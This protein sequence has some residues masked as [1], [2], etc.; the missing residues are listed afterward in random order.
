MRRQ[1]GAYVES[2]AVSEAE[3]AEEAEALVLGA[4]AT[5]ADD[6]CA[7]HHR[8]A[9]SRGEDLRRGPAPPLQL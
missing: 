3:S 5:V 2:E 8:R 6:N 9:S 1:A 4:G 7:A